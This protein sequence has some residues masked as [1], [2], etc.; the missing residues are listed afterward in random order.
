MAKEAKILINP[1][2]IDSS[3]IKDFIQVKD[4]MDIFAYDYL[5][6]YLSHEDWMK[7][8]KTKAKAQSPDVEMICKVFSTL[9]QNRSAAFC[10]SS[11]FD[12]LNVRIKQGKKTKAKLF[13][14]EDLFDE[15]E[16][17][18][19]DEERIYLGPE[20]DLSYCPYD[21]DP[22]YVDEEDM[23]M[24][25][26]L[27]NPDNWATEEVTKTKTVGKLKETVKPKWSIFFEKGNK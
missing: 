23:Q 14:K 6:V 15:I 13:L 25:A 11:Q 24:W 3:D 1:E 2:K 8:F 21:I 4:N 10:S 18:Y 26:R 7:T 12:E 22:N 9:R 20:D 17:P 27:S 19:N 5:L 16:E